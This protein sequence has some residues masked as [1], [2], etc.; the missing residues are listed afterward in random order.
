MDPGA[1]NT[2]TE[3]GMIWADGVLPLPAGSLPGTA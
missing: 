1:V 2:P 3:I